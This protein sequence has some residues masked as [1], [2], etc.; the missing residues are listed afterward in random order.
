MMTTKTKI[1]GVE[2]DSYI[3]NASGPL[4][5]TLDELENIANSKS[6]AIMMKSCTIEPREG[7]QEPRYIRL[8]LGSIQS[9]GLPNLGYQEYVKFSSQLKKYNKPIIASVAGLSVDD[10]EKM[11]SAFQDS[12][13]DLIEV[14]LSCPNLEGKP[15]V[16]YDFEQTEKVL[17]RISNLGKKPIGLK[18]PPYY[19]FIHHKQMADLIEK[20]K[21]DFITCTNSIGNTLIIDPETETPVIK[22]K[23]GFGGLSGNY[24]KPIALAN[25][26]AFYELLGNK[27]SIFGVGGIKTGADAF[28]FLLAGADAVQ[29]ATTFEKEGPSCFARI[30]S[31]LEEILQRK[32]YNSIEEVKGKLKYL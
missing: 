26:R 17:R 7:N 29:V 28:E 2:L 21:I 16:A 31:E 23:K 10:Y 3:C 22:P 27:I 11:V 19:D 18:L 9:M 32:G 20:Y 24:I 8:P 25:V 12:N 13:V 4:D 1:A 6:S 14:N 5:S 15:Q 30:N